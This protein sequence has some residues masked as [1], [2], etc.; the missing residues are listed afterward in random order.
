MAILAVCGAHPNP[1]LFEE[2]ANAFTK[3]AKNTATKYSIRNVIITSTH[4]LQKLPLTVINPPADAPTEIQLPTAV[5]PPA[6]SLTEAE[7]LSY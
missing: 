1:L 5:D 4:Q 2:T 3:L 6:I 7:I